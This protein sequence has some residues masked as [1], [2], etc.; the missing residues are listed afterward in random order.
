MTIYI[1]PGG[2]RGYS[3]HCINLPQ[4]VKE[5]AS[6]LPRFPKDLPVITCIVKMKSKGN[7]V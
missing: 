3:G 1:K 2:Q 6:S 7:T 5:L 4:Q